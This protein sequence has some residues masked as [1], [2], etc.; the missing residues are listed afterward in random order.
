MKSQIFKKSV[1]FL[2]LV[3][4]P[5]SFSDCDKE[6]VTEEKEF[7]VVEVSTETEWDFWV[8][9]KDGSNFFLQHE[10]NKPTAVYFQPDKSQDGFTI[11]FNELGLPSK[12]IIDDNII[13][14]ENF[15][16]DLVDAAIINSE[17]EISFFRDITIDH[18][19][20]QFVTGNK[21]N[22]LDQQDLLEI[23]ELSISVFSCVTAIIFPNPLS[24]LACSATII[25]LL[26]AEF[27]EDIEFLQFGSTTIDTYVNAL[28]CMQ[29]QVL[30]CFLAA[31]STG[32]AIK[33]S[34]LEDLEDNQENMS[35]AEGVLNGSAVIDIKNTT[36]DV[37]IIFN[38]TTTWHADVTFYEDGTT[39]YDEPANPGVYLT[40]GTWSL[41]NNQIHWDIGLGSSYIFDGTIK[42]Y[43]MS[44]TFVYAGE[45]KTWSAIKK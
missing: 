11:F 2:L 17:G 31:A 45:I 40:Y 38:A 39:K 33:N 8:A 29:L 27:G 32:L 14:L 5:L 25:K 4:F 13:L 23:A 36:W 12:G 3:I 42:D 28:Q 6:D 9:A 15:R 44:G 35:I 37:T 10:N 19:L 7:C 24:V 43:S 18:D 34:A 16:K 1:L 41:N 26:V 20:T 22:T 30:D 21:G